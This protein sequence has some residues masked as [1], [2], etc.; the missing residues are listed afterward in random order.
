[1]GTG[2]SAAND[3]KEPVAT[4][5]ADGGK[6]KGKHP[7]LIS[8]ATI[9]RSVDEPRKG[10]LLRRSSTVV[11]CG[12]RKSVAN[13]TMSKFYMLIGDIGGT[14][15]RLNLWEIGRN[16]TY[17]QGG[18][19]PGKKIYHQEY[20]NSEYTSF[21]NV[22][23]DFFA[24]CPEEA[25]DVIPVSAC[26][27]VAGPVDGNAVAFTNRA[28]W[29]ID[30]NDLQEELQI[31]HIRLINDFVAN[32]YG[33]LTL[34]P[35]E[36][37]T[38]QDAPVRVGAPIA[39][40]GA[41]TG[42]GETFLTCKDGQYDAWP[43]E[44]GHAEF[45]PR[46]ELQIRLLHFLMHKFKE[47]HRVSVERIVSGIGLVNVYEFLRQEFPDKAS[48][49]VDKELAEAGDMGGRVVAVHASTDELC[50]QAMNIMVDVYGAETGVCALKFL[51]F[52]GLYIAG[53]LAPKNMS[54]FKT[55]TFMQAYADK[56][57]VS[58][59]LKQ[60][61]IKIVLAE[62]I[63]QRGALLVAFRALEKSRKELFAGPSSVGNTGEG[64]NALRSSAQS[65]Q[66]SISIYQ[67]HT[68]KDLVMTNKDM[69][70]LDNETMSL[71]TIEA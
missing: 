62:N 38:I 53:G 47:R 48:A 7:I 67:R 35:E 69:Q 65:V 68:T 64:Y 71:E 61:P 63:G 13:I 30:G 25:Q 34:N 54:F 55:P 3:R 5:K 37:Y 52:G 6:T 56:G 66:S 1:M 40:I 17:I 33:L 27:A 45:A 19:L 10:P 31:Q 44:G 8:P 57:R 24:S 14:N 59:A 51:P 60:V 18:P 23:Q 36:T 20:L 12:R 39:C 28:G 49:A 22:V 11:S 58:P 70:A 9:D 26:F 16:D 21:K 46:D 4:I 42:L 32:G 50:K 15:S 43:S 29:V 2:A 41:G